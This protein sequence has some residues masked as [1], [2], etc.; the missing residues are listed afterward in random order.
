MTVRCPVC[1]A[2][3]VARTNGPF[4]VVVCPRATCKNTKAIINTSREKAL[5]QFV[6][7]R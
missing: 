2:E 7:G 4:T 6:D 5:R 1:K 3:A